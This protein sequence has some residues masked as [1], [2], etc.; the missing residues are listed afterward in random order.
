MKS[1]KSLNQNQILVS[2][3]VED[4]SAIAGGV[5]EVVR[6]LSKNLFK[7]NINSQILHVKGEYSSSYNA[8]Q[9]TASGPLGV[10]GFNKNLVS[11]ISNSISFTCDNT[12]NLAHIHGIWSAIQYF[13]A[14]QALE[15][16]FHLC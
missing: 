15:K 1:D 10:W 2:H 4:F 16:K 12:K 14:R 6:Q 7:E 13:S 9:F 3:F 8:Q 11:Q 5:P